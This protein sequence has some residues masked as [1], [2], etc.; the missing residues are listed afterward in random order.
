M[1][2]RSLSLSLF[3]AYGE[4]GRRRERNKKLGWERQRRLSD[5]C[6][7]SISNFCFCGLCECVC[8]C[9]CLSLPVESFN[10]LL[11]NSSYLKLLNTFPRPHIHY[12][13]LSSLFYF[14]PKIN[15]HISL[16]YTSISII[17]LKIWSHKK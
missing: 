10:Q 15:I 11:E 2:N 14:L 9:D 5:L 16:F 13:V 7:F 3:C 6:L 17:A 1:N 4:A 12:H 8:V